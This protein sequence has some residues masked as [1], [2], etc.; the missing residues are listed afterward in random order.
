M[1][2]TEVEAVAEQDRRGDCNLR[3]L[4]P[5]ADI[6][7]EGGHRSGAVPIVTATLTVARS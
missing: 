1:G 7:D 5:D 2:L 3:Q 4:E 6:A